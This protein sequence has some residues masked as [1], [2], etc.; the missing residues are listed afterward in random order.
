MKITLSDDFEKIDP[1]SLLLK[2]SKRKARISVVGDAMIDQYHYVR[3]DRVSPEF[4]IP[5]MTQ[6][7][8]YPKEEC[9]GGAGNV[10]MQLKP[11]N[12]DIQFFGFLNQYARSVLQESGLNTE[13]CVVKDHI[14]VPEK[15]R[16]YQ[17]Q[18]PLCR[19][20]TEKKNYGLSDTDLKAFQH[21][22]FNKAVAAPV[23]DVYILS[24]YGKGVFKNGGGKMWL[25]YLKDHDLCPVIV[26]D[27]KGGPVSD[28]KGCSIIKPNSKEAKEMSGSSDWQDQC[29][30]F[31]N[32]AECQAVIITQEGKGVV[33]NVLG[34]EFEYR[35]NKEVKAESVIGAG[36]C[37]VAVIA[38]GMAY[39]IDIVDAVEI[40]FEAGHQYVQRKHNR[41]VFPYELTNDFDP[42]ML[43]DRDF[44]L[45]FTNGCFDILHAGHIENLKFAKSRAD[46]LVVALNTDESVQKMDKGHALINNLEHRRK[47][48]EALDCVDFVVEFDDETPYNLISTIKPDVLVKG[49]EYENPVGSDLVKEVA[50]APMVE[51]ISTSSIIDKI[52]E[53]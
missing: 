12:V 4:P 3:A 22:L 9:P 29:D 27:P 11:W 7:D 39:A 1:I 37:F 10:A 16:Y 26:V 34:R 21:Q 49:S 18:F 52:R 38:L 41:P 30:Y 17:G 48:I 13:N 43:A 20:D 51:G 36:D 35:P 8:D 6:E 15:C 44:T 24:D 23:T 42:A 32:E 50:L 5:V 14:H 2:K 40:A 53:P 25:N 47:V 31:M 28:W 46:K 19:L 45:A 33:G